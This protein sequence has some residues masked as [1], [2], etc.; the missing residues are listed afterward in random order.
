VFDKYSDAC[1]TREEHSS[2]EPCPPRAVSANRRSADE[3]EGRKCDPAQT[4]LRKNSSDGTVE[5]TSVGHDPVM[6]VVVEILD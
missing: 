2:T 5:G 1:C 3:N 6:D 4:A